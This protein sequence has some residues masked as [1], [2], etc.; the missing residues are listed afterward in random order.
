MGSHSKTLKT[1]SIIAVFTFIAGLAPFIFNF[2]ID[3]YEINSIVDLDLAKSKISEKSHYPLW[4]VIHYPEETAEIVVLGDSRARALKE[5]FWHQLGLSNT[6]N[7]AYGGATIH[8]LYDTFRYI[9]HSP[10]LK[11]LVVGIQLRSFDPNHKNGMNRV[12]E[13]L[14]LSG[15]PLIYYSNWFVSRISTKLMKKKYATQIHTLGQLEFSPIST[16]SANTD[17]LDDRHAYLELLDEELCKNCKLPSNISPSP[18]TVATGKH[19]FYFGDGLG[20][21]SPLWPPIVSRQVLSG[22]FNSQVK[23]NARSDWD[24]FQFSEQL[25]SRL[26][27][28]ANWTKDNDVK[29][30]FVI[31][32]TIV[33][34]QQR[35]VDFG[36]GELNHNFRIRL[37]NLA[38]V[39]DFDFN[40]PMTRNVD[41]FTD[42]YHFNYL[43]AKQ[44]I[45]EISMHI[46]SNEEI[47]KRAI[48]RR[49]QIVCPLSSEVTETTITDRNIEVL[50]GKAC[51]IWRI[52]HEE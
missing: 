5:K 18:H 24:K 6:Y 2:V 43:A 29:L 44:I 20:I 34:M 10:N 50:E 13:A 42:A 51:R 16:A 45:G 28:I 15:N 37:A 23:K 14:R 47:L 48:K 26:V 21:W 9:K 52:R 3:P 31:P 41:N 1:Y 22:S 30:V 39:L 7:F 12:P 35:I 40:S 8:E 11:T 27:E 32:P 38:P 46:T 33:E 19:A 49:K 17:S 4:K 36:F 25:W